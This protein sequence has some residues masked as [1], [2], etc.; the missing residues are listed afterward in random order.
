MV[1]VLSDFMSG[2]DVG[3]ALFFKLNDVF[4]LDLKEKQVFSLNFNGFFLKIWDVGQSYFY[5]QYSEINPCHSG[6]KLKKKTG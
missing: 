4:K 1:L 2:D 3:V 5:R 6:S